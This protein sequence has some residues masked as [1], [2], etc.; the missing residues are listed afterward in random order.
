MITQNKQ[1]LL[2]INKPSGQLNKITIPAHPAH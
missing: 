1:P 2:F